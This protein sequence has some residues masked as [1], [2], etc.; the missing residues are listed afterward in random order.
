MNDAGDTQA[1]LSEQEFD[2]VSVNDTLHSN[3]HSPSK[4]QESKFSVTSLATMPKHQSLR[5]KA[6]IVYGTNAAKMVNKYSKQHAVHTIAVGD[7]AT[8]RIDLASTAY[9]NLH[10]QLL[11]LLVNHSTCYSLRCSAGVIQMCYHSG[12]LELFSG[13]FSIS[14]D[15][16]ENEI[17]VTL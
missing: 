12:D 13:D 3:S 15:L 4:V 11:I 6:D 9:S 17:R 7:Y 2:N 5:H 14:V 1:V 8:L 16:W 10:V